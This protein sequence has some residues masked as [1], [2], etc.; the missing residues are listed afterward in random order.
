MYQMLVWFRRTP[1]RLAECDGR[2]NSDFDLRALSEALDEQRR[3]REM[4][5]KSRTRGIADSGGHP[6]ATA[7]HSGMLM[8]FAEEGR[9]AFH[10]LI[11]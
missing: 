6:I 5:P 2:Q 4:R 9:I 1:D 10:T 11:R 7:F 8:N 3:S